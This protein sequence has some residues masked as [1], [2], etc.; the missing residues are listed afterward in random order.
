MKS[1]FLK[2]TL[3]LATTIAFI[4]CDKDFNS[5]DSDLA[6]DDHFDLEKH[7][8]STVI[9]YSKA[10]GPVQSN[11]LPV[12]ALGVH[13]NSVF[14][15]TKANFV[16]QLE[17]ERTAP[18]IGTNITIDAI[19][20]SVYM[21]VPYFSHLDLDATEA[22]T[23]ILDSIYG[24]RESTHNLKIYRNGYV[25]RDFSPSPDP[26]DVSSY[27]Q[28]YYNDEKSFVES[29][30][31]SVQLNDN[32]NTAENTAFKFSKEQIVKYKTNDNGE[33]LDASGAVTTD[34]AKRVVKQKFPPGMWINLNKNYFKQ[35]ILETASINLVNNSNFRDYFKGLY[36][37]IEENSGQQGA[38]AMIDFSKAKIY[39]QYHSDITT[40][41]GT[42]STTTNAKRELVLNL[43]G[44]TVNFYEYDNDANYQNLLTN[45]NEITGDKQLFLKGG[46]GSVVYIDLF[47]NT[48]ALKIVESTDGVYSLSPGSNKVPDELD[49]L[50]LN[51][52]LINNANLTFY[53]DNTNSG[54]EPTGGR[55][56]EPKRIYLYDAT[57]N[58]VL[59]DYTFDGSTATNPKNNKF[60][61]DGRI[62]V[63]ENKKGTYYRV[64]ITN[65][66][67]SLINSEDK[68]LKNNVKLGLCVTENINISNNGSLKTF[69]PTNNVLESDPL[70]IKFVPIASSFGPL[71]TV[72][73]GNHTNVPDDKKLK[74]QI[75][76]TKPN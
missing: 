48:D 12:N 9:A 21:Y 13:K 75:F 60:G 30:I 64:N 22:D 17:L 27:F 8:V 1:N 65:Y 38:L 45:A 67:N 4:S 18:T 61:F 33:W 43:K 14:G 52:W 39:I 15:T 50:R 51:G 57:N 2:I 11:N 47:G 3:L 56:S 66:I 31:A 44:N 7:D 23:Y 72:L 19:K 55:P 74:L 29:N 68:N 53:I 26:S 10:T 46:E 24:D 63:D 25:L 32:S 71:G 6:D 28:K 76:Y 34:V 41:T 37:Q 59:A 58:R 16:T 5:L 42:G 20:D 73:Y 35:N 70:Q 54:M 36:F 40:T 62:N 49:Q 69:F